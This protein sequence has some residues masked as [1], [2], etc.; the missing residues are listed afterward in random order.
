MKRE[1]LLLRSCVQL[2]LCGLLQLFICHS[3]LA[4]SGT[5]SVRGVVTDPQGRAVAGAVV[6]LTNTEKSFSRTQ[7]SSDDGAYAFS[8][9][10]PGNY[11]VEAEATGF[12]KASVSEVR[13]LVETP[14]EINVQLE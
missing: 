1:R 14:V 7:T 13:A 9:I 3:V 4:Q 2:L 11:R 10:P 12:K 6:T 8:A 5:S